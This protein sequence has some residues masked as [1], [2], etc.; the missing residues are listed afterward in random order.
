MLECTQSLH[1]IGVIPWDV[2]L[3]TCGGVPEPLFTEKGVCEMLYKVSSN[4]G[5]DQVCADLQTAITDRKF[6]VMT[7]HDL[8]ETMKK[9]GVEFDRAC[10]IYEVCNPQKA[11]QVLMAHMDMS[12]ALPCRI[13][14]YEEGE[15]VV[16]ATLKP[17][18][19]MPMFGVSGL[20]ETA[21]EVES[22]MVASMNEAAGG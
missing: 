15:Q 17:T 2:L 7:V 14:I 11:K 18:M 3:G 20:D 5:I 13:S 22:V 9:K 21:K 16:L 8:T 10:R 12:T 19:L 4:K 1:E 6:G